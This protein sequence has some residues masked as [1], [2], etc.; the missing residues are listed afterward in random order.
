[1]DVLVNVAAIAFLAAMAVY[2]GV[3]VANTVRAARLAA[4]SAEAEQEYLRERVAGLMAHRR[5]E[6]ER[7]EL[8]WNGFRKFQI[9]RKSLECEGIRSF[10]LRPHDRK[11]L[12]PFNPG[13]YLTFRLNIAGQ[14]KPVVRCYSLS[15]SPKGDHYRVTI[16]K[17]PPPRDK[18]DAPPGLSSSFFY[19]QLHEGD[20]VDVKAPSGHFYL[21]MTK[22]A[23]AV[24][25]AGGVGITPVLS[26]LN[27]IVETGSKRETW[28]FLGVRNSKEHIMKDHLSAIARENENVHLHVCYSNPGEDDVAGEDYHH[29]ERVSVDLLRNLLPSNNYEFYFCGPPPMMNSLAEGLEA[30]GVP[31]S[32][33]NYEAF[34]PATVKKVQKAPEIKPA[35]A[36]AIEVK[37]IKSGKSC[38]WD[39][40]IGNLLEFAEANGVSIDFGCRAGNCGTCITAIKSGEVRYVGEP[41]EMPEAGSCLTCISVPKGSLALDA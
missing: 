11:A 28:F 27:A 37:F 15:D 29:G 8:S 32:D 39:P 34:G 23:P 3:F 1:M 30:W 16:K 21:D 19:D 5:F 14:P 24:L 4:R 12:P 41:G 40:E 26:M 9:A 10:Y 2:T 20:I 6:R 31:E 25:I 17:L 13:Q 7:T 18:P 22:Q 35:E 36:A 33:V 38:A